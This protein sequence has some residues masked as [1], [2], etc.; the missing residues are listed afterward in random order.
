MISVTT[1]PVAVL[2]ALTPA[3]PQTELPAVEHTPAKAPQQTG[4]HTGAAFLQLG[5]LLALDAGWYEWQI[6]LNK[7][8][9]DFAR[10]FEG[11]WKR[12]A[13]PAGHRFDDNDRYLNV[14]HAFMGAVYYQIARAHGG[15]LLQATLFNIAASTT[16]E[17]TVEHREVVSVNDQ[18][19]TGLGGVPIGEALF[20]ASDVFARGKPTLRNR[21]LMG[22][23]SPMRVPA[24]LRGEGAGSS[25]TYDAHGLDASVPHRFDLAFGA[26]SGVAGSSARDVDSAWVANGRLDLEVIAAPLARVTDDGEAATRSAK[27]RGGEVSRFLVDWAG[28]T[29][30]MRTFDLAARTMLFGRADSRRSMRGGAARLLGAASAFDVTYN[31][32]GGVDDFFTVAHIAGP[33]ADFAWSRDELALRA[34]ASAYGDFA[35]VRPMAIGETSVAARGDMDGVKSTLSRFDYYYGWGGTAALRLE[36]RYGA[37]R[38]GTS[39]EWNHVDSI[40]GLDRHQ[41]A[42]VSPTGVPHEAVRDDS[43]LTDERLRARLFVEAPLPFVDDLRLGVAGDYTHRSGTWQA[44]DLA[45]MRD[46]LRLGV[47]LGAAL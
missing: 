27:L 17:V 2:L 9:F 47:T 5:A 38:A 43:N 31:R 12:L 29:D 8:D 3:A 10:S 23:L 22:V 15:S 30:R 14:G 20:R 13:T 45:D 4:M 41:N 37:F 1:L 28:T 18:I 11:Q 32:A 7:Q 35:M 33:T 6:E 24:L 21:I 36:A 39:G 26:T 16:W 25:G 42:Y 34:E 46:D 44:H 40:E 19:V